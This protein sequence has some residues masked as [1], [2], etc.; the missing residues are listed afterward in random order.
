VIL[1]SRWRGV[2]DEQLVEKVYNITDFLCRE[3]RKRRPMQFIN[4]KEVAHMLGVA[5]RTIVEWAK[6]YAES[7]RTEGLPAYRF[8]R[9]AWSFDKEEV[10][11]WIEKKKSGSAQTA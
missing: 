10:K 8:G 3:S 4:A 5:D 9:R 7:G 6:Q 11:R 2:G 1:K